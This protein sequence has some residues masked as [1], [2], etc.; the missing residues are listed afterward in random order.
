MTQ[1]TE[2]ID[3]DGEQ[4][5]KKSLYD[6]MKEAVKESSTVYDEAYQK[7]LTDGGARN[8]LYEFSG[9]AMEGIIASGANQLMNTSNSEIAIKTAKELL[10]QLEADK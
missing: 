5:V 3:H 8:W 2:T 10:T 1:V 4:W 6:Q 7:G 9:R